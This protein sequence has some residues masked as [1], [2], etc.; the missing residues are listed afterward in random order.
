MAACQ[1]PI[2]VMPDDIPAH[3]YAV[4]MEA[5]MRAEPFTRGSTTREIPI[6]VRHLRSFP[7]SHC[8]ATA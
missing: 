2:L 8:T 7:K 4:A 5:L 6:A 1:T 3:P